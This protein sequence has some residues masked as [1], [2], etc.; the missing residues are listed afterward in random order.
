MAKE[1]E[2]SPCRAP[3]ESAKKDSVGLSNLRLNGSV[4]ENLIQLG[5][6]MQQLNA[7]V[8]D[9]Q[10][11]ADVKKEGRAVRHHVV[12]T[13]LTPRFPA[14][15]NGIPD[16]WVALSH[17]EALVSPSPV[18]QVRPRTRYGPSL[19]TAK[20]LTPSNVGQTTPSILVK[21][22]QHGLDAPERVARPARFPAR[23]R[24]P[25]PVYGQGRRDVW[26]GPRI[27]SSGAVPP[28]ERACRPRQ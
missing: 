2:E 28:S 11:R 1:K 9:L 26:D 22:D 24:S 8:A 10:K 23:R 12:S 14:D 17:K 16:A 4:S 27:P 3:V 13:P 20:A 19:A 15:D 21:Q 18:V 7:A 25:E 6:Q 5:A